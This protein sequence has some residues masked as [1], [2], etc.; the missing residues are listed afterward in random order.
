MW[1]KV[2]D[3]YRSAQNC[4]LHCKT[5]QQ[6]GLCVKFNTVYAM[7]QVI[8]IMQTAIILFIILH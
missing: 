8:L 2:F 4:C 7:A 5:L 6:R 3:I 1:A